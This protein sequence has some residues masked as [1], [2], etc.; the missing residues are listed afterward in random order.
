MFSY[1]L[2][3]IL[4][5]VLGNNL[6]GWWGWWVGEEKSF[7]FHIWCVVLFSEFYGICG[8]LVLYLKWVDFLKR[9]VGGRLAGGWEEMQIFGD[10][11]PFFFNITFP[12]NPRQP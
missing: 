9:G 6:V 3:R 12:P 11:S 4:Y 8:M 1:F 5:S 10:V 7:V 2:E